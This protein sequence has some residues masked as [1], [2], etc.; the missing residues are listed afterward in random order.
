MKRGIIFSVFAL[1]MAVSGYNTIYA[2]TP[3][4][5][6]FDSFDA[7]P[8]KGEG[9]VIIHQSENIKKLVGT[10]IDNEN[11][12]VSEGK[13]YLLTEGYRIQVYSGNNQRI[14]KEEASTLQTKIKEVFID[15]EADV[16]YNAPFWRLHV[17][18]YRSFEEASLMLRELRSLFPQKKNEIY[19]IEDVIRLPLD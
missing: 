13:T 2:Q 17:G 11:V 18:N 19:I 3:H 5:S 16:K 9:V 4:F 7:P 12:V 14:S 8:K 6:I 15:T 10:R 1:L